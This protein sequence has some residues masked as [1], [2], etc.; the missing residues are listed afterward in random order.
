MSNLFLN[1]YQTAKKLINELKRN[2]DTIEILIKDFPENKT[3]ETLIGFNIHI[4]SN[5]SAIIGIECNVFAD[6]NIFQTAGV[7]RGNIKE[8]FLRYEQTLLDAGLI[9]Y[10]DTLTD[11]QKMYYY[12]QLEQ[13]QRAG[14]Q[15]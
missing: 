10:G 6:G 9:E 1:Q 8:H 13:Q 2:M 14:Y 12:E 5:L 11:E 15:Y 7:W 3:I 4:T